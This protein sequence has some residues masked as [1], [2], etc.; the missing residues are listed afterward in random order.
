MVRGCRAEIAGCS[1]EAY[2]HLRIKDAAQLMMYDSEAELLDYARSVCALA[3]CI[4]RTR[5]SS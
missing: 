3:W 1:E 4:V 2:V 5:G